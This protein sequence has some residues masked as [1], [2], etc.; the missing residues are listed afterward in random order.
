MVDH[1]GN[2]ILLNESY[3][4]GIYI[5]NPLLQYKEKKNIVFNTS[6][7]DRAYRIDSELSYFE[8][9]YREGLIAEDYWIR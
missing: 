4:D 3:N 8:R 2:M 5:T 9:S 1:R 6:R 7:V